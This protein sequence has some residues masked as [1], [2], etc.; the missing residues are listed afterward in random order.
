MA[1]RPYL[2]ETKLP[3]S[4]RRSLFAA[5]KCLKLTLNAQKW[6]LGLT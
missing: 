3:G 6:Q 2:R 5:K 1:V 4:T